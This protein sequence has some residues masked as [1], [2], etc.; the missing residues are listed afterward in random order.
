VPAVLAR[1]HRQEIASLRRTAREIKRMLAAQR[2]R[3]ERITTFERVWS[4]EDW[5]RHYL[6]HPLLSGI[7]RRLVWE[8]A[9]GKASV[10][11]AWDEERGC[12]VD[13]E[14]RPVA[15]QPA[16]CIRLWHPVRCEAATIEAWRRW[17]DTHGVTQPFAQAHRTIFRPT[18]AE[19]ARAA[20][21]R[22]AGFILYQHQLAAVCR[23]RGWRYRLTGVGFETGEARGATLDLQ[24]WRLHAELEI[25]PVE[26]LRETSAAGAWFLVTTGRLVFRTLEGCEVPL[27]EIPALVCSEVMR[28]V[29]I[30]VDAALIGIDPTRRPPGAARRAAPAASR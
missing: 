10:Q 11:V 6:E 13:V 30:F 4:M 24:P 18:E 28:D 5:R 12:L 9:D 1:D 20:S 21:D 3:L 27:G 29:D 26:N 7:A 16:A 17:I 2:S 23:H 14:D 15:P 25:T 8:T 22:F 19:H